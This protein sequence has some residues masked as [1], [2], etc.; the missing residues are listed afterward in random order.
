METLRLVGERSLI[1]PLGSFIPE[2]MFSSLTSDSM[3]YPIR[4]RR[5]NRI[6][7]SVFVRSCALVLILAAL[8]VQLINLITR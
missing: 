6:R 5:F 8:A 7:R 1:I 2:N 3:K 4:T